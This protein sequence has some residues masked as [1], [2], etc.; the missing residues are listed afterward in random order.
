MNY[1]IIPS[2]LFFSAAIALVISNRIQTRRL[3]DSLERM[4][5]QAMTGSFKSEHFDES[6]LSKL[7]SELSEYL[8]SSSLS[9]Q[10]VQAEKDKLKELIS[11]ISH[12][13]KTPITNLVLYS[14]LLEDANL[15]QEEKTN[16]TAIR[17]QTE[18][19]RFLIDSLV[20]LS[21]LENGIISLEKKKNKLLP[22]LQN[23]CSQLKEKAAS[24]GLELVLTSVDA[25]AIIDEKWTQEALFNIADNA[26]KYTE[27]GSISFE[28]S[29]YPMFIRVD[30]S[31]TG[32]GIPEEEQTKIF[33][34]FYRAAS[35][36]CEEG[37][38]LGL[39][40]AR[41]IVNGQGGYIKVSSNASNS[42]SESKKQSSH[43]TTFSVFL[44]R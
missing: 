39:H 28:I 30:I 9:A 26:V 14:E 13:T 11:D 22:I 35:V 38:G 20:K 8:S 18:K 1:I 43:G 40:L 17:T 34:R 42:F 2:L 31:D 24:K 6:R 32:P 41:E 4:L 15:S 25:E 16:V 36:K 10:N 27:K 3:L 7:E 23:I 19:L 44:P 29:Q 21:R 33:G 12:Q 5:K 37:V